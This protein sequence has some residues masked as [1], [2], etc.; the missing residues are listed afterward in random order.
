MLVFT[1]LK[2]KML[3]NEEREQR[4]L[5]QKKNLNMSLSIRDHKIVSEVDLG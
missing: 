3:K 2:K 5:G 4:Y 1:F